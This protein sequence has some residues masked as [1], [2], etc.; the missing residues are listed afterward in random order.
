LQR[1][2]DVFNY[3]Y[4]NNHLNKKKRLRL[5]NKPFFYAH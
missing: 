1:I 3:I 5:E 4:I 2:I